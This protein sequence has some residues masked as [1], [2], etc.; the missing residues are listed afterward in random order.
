M[1]G[2]KDCLANVSICK[3][4]V[5]LANNKTVVCK[6]IGKLL[7]KI[8]GGGQLRLRN[9]LYIPDM[10]GTLIS[11]M[12]LMKTHDGRTNMLVTSDACTIYRNKE[13]IA[14]EN[15]DKDSRLYMIKGKLVRYDAANAISTMDQQ[16]ICHMRLGHLPYSAINNLKQASTG[17]P[18]LN[19]KN[20]SLCKGCVK[21][22]AFET[23]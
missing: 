17:L 23:T 3:R 19:F 21:G 18:D 13:I 9:V 2:E 7:I 12:K 8:K 15:F 5:S 20:E 14:R 16:E 11:A 10:D 4:T 6:R 22:S 1:T